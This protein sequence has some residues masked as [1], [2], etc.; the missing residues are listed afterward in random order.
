MPGRCALF[1]HVLF[2]VCFFTLSVLLA[3]PDVILIARLGFVAWYPATGLILACL[4]AVSPW[5]SLVAGLAAALAGLSFYKQPLVCFRQLSDICTLAGYAAA[6]YLLRGPLR[7]DF[8]LRRQRDVLRYLSLTL[9]AAVMASLLGVSGLVADGAIRPSELW[10]SG[11]SWFVGDGVALLG[12]APFLLIHVFPWVRNQLRLPSGASPAPWEPA[13]AQANRFGH[14][15]ETSGQGIVILLALF[16]MFGPRWTSLQLFYL[17]FIPI[18]WMAMRQGVRQAAVGLLVLNFGVVICMNAY[19]PQSRMLT[20]VCL[21]MLVLSATGLILGS[22]VTER[23]H[24]EVELAQALASSEEALKQVADQKFALDRHAIELN[25]AKEAAEAANRAKSEFLANMSHEIRT[26]MNGIIGMTELALQTD[27]SPEQRECLSLVKSSA[28]SLLSLINDILD[29]S[30]IEAGKLTIETTDFSLRHSLQDLLNELAVRAHQKGLELNCHIPPPVPDALTGDP[31]RLRQI[32]I[33][34]LGNALKFTARGEITLHVE[35]GAERARRA[36][37]HFRVSDTGIGIPPEKQKM[38]FE[39]F[40]QSDSST[41]REYG[42]TGLGLSIS[43]RLVALMGGS[44]WVESEP[45]RGS[46]FHFKVP[47]GVRGLALPD[48]QAVELQALRGLSV[49]IVDDNTTN[50]LILR[51]TL[52]HWNMKTAEAADGERALSMLRAGKLAGDHYDLLLLDAQMPHIDGFSVAAQLRQNPDLTRAVVIMLSSAGAARD[53]ARCRELGIRAYLSKPVKQD[54]LLQAIRTALGEQCEKSVTPIASPRPKTDEG[55]RLRILLAEDN[56]VNQ[57]VATRFLE[58]AGHSV[59]VAGSGKKAVACWQQEAFD[60][61]LM[62][63]QM[64]EMDGFEATSHIRQME[65]AAGRRTPIIAM[66]A[67]AMWVTANVVWP[68]AW[69]TTCRN[70]SRPTLCSRPSI[71]S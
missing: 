60:L 56:V 34:L 66:T 8:A 38:I 70:R 37:F 64:P 24:A 2:S 6:A 52:T 10:A 39:A 40:S 55:R 63:I 27:L 68:R 54:A 45:G 21:L 19:P 33:N 53:T 47:L 65:A 35:A 57:K 32:L 4:I 51:E 29:F 46:T 36:D 43:A 16:V 31:T 50:R 44:I 58:K 20:S 13:T 5:Y 62:D 25:V 49:L 59:A 11:L 23:R 7:I 42:G 3:S 26:P 1:R 69:T 18:L 61:V 15:L 9:A 12:V 30:K 71:A 48:A 14:L 28:D 17:G 22:V 67:H 41:T